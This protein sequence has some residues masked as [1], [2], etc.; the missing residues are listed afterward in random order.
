M[1]QFKIGIVGVGGVGGYLGGM[2]ACKYHD[3]ATVEITFIAR[4]ENLRIIKAA[5]LK[6]VTDGNERT[7]YPDH[8]FTDSEATQT[9]DLL[10]LCVKSYDL[11]KTLQALKG[12]LKDTTVILPFLNGVDAAERIKTYL[13]DT[14]VLTGCC[15][16]VARLES[17]GNVS[18]SGQLKQFFIGSAELEADAL[19]RIADLFLNAGIDL[20][21]TKDIDQTLWTKFLFISPFASITSAFDRSLGRILS[22]SYYKEILINLMAELKTLAE[23]KGITFQDGIVDT[24]LGKMALIPYE[25]TSSMHTD[26]KKK[27]RSEAESITGY[28]V[29]EAAQL[30]LTVPAYTK[31]LAEIRKTWNL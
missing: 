9:Y 3:V 13:P 18:V 27:N 12:C 4:G 16:I 8:I 23:A 20:T 1:E 5:G 29:E 7:V 14:V 11:E 28:V 22:N 19:K 6:L 15:Y 30:G 24:L 26:L 21:V 31:M 17:P 25:A 2:L 10:I